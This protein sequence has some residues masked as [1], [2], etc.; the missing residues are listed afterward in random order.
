M[1]LEKSRIYAG[2]ALGLIFYFL[3]LGSCS[4][5]SE[6]RNTISFKDSVTTVQDSI[7]LMTSYLDRIKDADVKNLFF[8]HD[9]YLYI[10]N[11]KIAR[12]SIGDRIDFLDSVQHVTGLS[13]SDSYKL[14]SLA[15]FLKDNNISACFKHHFFGEYFYEYR[16]TL[17]NDYE[18][19]RY[20]LIYDESLKDLK[21]SDVI[22]YQLLDR[23]QDLLL[24]APADIKIK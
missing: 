10:N 8:D 5:Q 13:K 15:L 23:K 21:G 9:D 14:V 17:E 12:M 6:V 24:I 22:S 20:I 3:F 16:P 7:K 18:D 4:S 1:H 2:V 11:V 19:I